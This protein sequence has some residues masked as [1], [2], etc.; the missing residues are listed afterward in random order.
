[1]Y[2]FHQIS[3]IQVDSMAPS[4]PPASDVLAT[5]LA[6]NRALRAR[7]GGTGNTPPIAVVQGKPSKRFQ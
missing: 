3:T 7:T 5:Q 2:V 4:T 6:Q 1:M